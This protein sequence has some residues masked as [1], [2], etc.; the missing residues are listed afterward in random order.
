MRLL[1]WSFSQI[2]GESSN[3]GDKAIFASMV[4]DIKK[5][6]PNAQIFSISSNPSYTRR[7][8]RVNASHFKEIHLVLRAIRNSD[9]VI[10]GGGEF[11]QDK[12]SLAYIIANLSIGALAIALRKPIVFLGIGVADAD[13]ISLIGRLLTRLVLNQAKL[14]TVRDEQSKIILKELKVTKPP[15]YV[16][17]DAALRLTMASGKRIDEIMVHEG[18]QRNHRF[19]VGVAPRRALFGRFSILPLG[20][21]IKLNIAPSAYYYQNRRLARILADTLDYLVSELDAE[22]VFI[23]MY[24]GKNFSYGDKDF[25]L[26]LAKMMCNKDRAKIISGTYSP[27]ELL[28]VFS[29]MDLV[30][31]MTLHSLIVATMMEVP[32][33]AISYSSKM[34]RF[35][36]TIEQEEHLIDIENLS[37]KKLLVKIDHVLSN[38]RLIRQGLRENIRKLQ[39]RASLNMKLLSDYLTQTEKWKREYT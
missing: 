33:V 27:G 38:K 34:N 19:L 18:I 29:R 8:Y 36:Y 13:E 5:I 1:I 32:T 23:P 6:L 30:I 24:V 16:T 14:I 15:V 22:I 3:F 7:H 21:Q 11:I 26:D 37:F 4:T 31:G 28:G 35:M 20:T 12:S 9:L 2:E 39:R 17:A 10:L 25:A